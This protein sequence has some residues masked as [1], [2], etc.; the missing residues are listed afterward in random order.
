MGSNEYF[1][2][3]Y[4]LTLRADILPC[5]TQFSVKKSKFLF[6]FSFEFYLFLYIRKILNYLEVSPIIFTIKNLVKSS[7]LFLLSPC[8]C[9]EET[10]NKSSHPEVFLGKVVLKLCS[11]FTGEHPCQSAISV[12]L[13]CN[14]IEITL[15]HGRSP[16]NI[17]SL[18]L[19]AA[20]V[21]CFWT[22]E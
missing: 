11:K 10:K 18:F 9:M 16:V 2:Y 20:L 13:L 1:H 3:H 7:K 15:Q 12:K 22:S 6:Y 19:R 4:L 14:F 5:I 8:C 17:E 21:G